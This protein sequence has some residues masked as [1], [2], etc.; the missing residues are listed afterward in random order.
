MDIIVLGVG[1]GDTILTRVFISLILHSTHVIFC[2][3]YI[4]IKKNTNKM[5]A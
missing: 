4:Y 3:L 1:I 2:F 5:Y